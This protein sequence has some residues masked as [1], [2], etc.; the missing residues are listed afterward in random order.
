MLETKNLNNG[1]YCVIYCRVSTKKQEE[2]GLSLKAQE[3]LLRGWAKDNNFHPVETFRVHESAS[4]PIRKGLRNMLKYCDDNGIKNILVEKVD[5]LNRNEPETEVLIDKY[6]NKHGFKFYLIKDNEILDGNLS[7]VGKFV[8]G[9]K[10]VTAG[11]IRD[12]LTE[13][14]QK[15]TKE[16]LEKGGYPGLPPLGY[17]AIPKTKTRPPQIVQTDDAPILK[18]FLET[19]N[20]GKF[21]IQQGIRLAQDMGLKPKTK[22]KFSKG[23]LAKLI[24]NRFYYGEFVWTHPGFNGGEQKIFKNKTMG[25]EPIIS[26][27]T[28][29]KNQ[30]ILK[31]R[32]KNFHKEKLRFKFNNLMTCDH[33]GRKIYGVQFDHKIGWETKK[34]LI[35]K[36]Y[37]Y[38][39][40]YT[41]VKGLWYTTDGVQVIPEEYVDKETLTIKRNVYSSAESGRKKLWLKKGSK[42]REE[43]CAVPSFKEKEVEQMLMDEFSLI[44]FNASHWKKVKEALFKDETKDFILHE[45][46]ILRSEQTKN[47]NA[48]NKLYDDYCEGIIDAEFFKSRSEKIRDRQQE[49]KD[50]L[51]DLEED[52]EHFDKRIG[53][54]IEVLDAMKNWSKVLKYASDE[55]K[56]HLIR[57]MTIKIFTIH[58]KVEKDGKVY[59]YKGLQFTYS[60]EV[61]ELFEIGILE[62]S[63]KKD[64]PKLSLTKLKKESLIVE[65]LSMPAATLRIPTQPNP[66]FFT[67][68]SSRVSGKAGRRGCTRHDFAK[69]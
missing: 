8:Y 35:E 16:K 63:M 51:V 40:Y 52:K 19:F 6:R 43:R 50:R 62:A 25:F 22:D 13:E 59:E 46:R 36:N 18:K 21:S 41:H 66:A 53:K 56:N 57:L 9:M 3:S 1:N 67:G 2:K 24:K 48:L 12:N 23:Q 15:G 68:G 64:T 42:V 61:R 5:R 49:I 27:K 4:R 60:P 20:S 28:W 30:E 45:I 34:G 65:K 37:K 10:K 7:A 14:C 17:K 58:D 39:P 29:E 47:E 11:Y 31:N 33:C 54:S 55:K 69:G 26:K 44:K 38:D 32:Q